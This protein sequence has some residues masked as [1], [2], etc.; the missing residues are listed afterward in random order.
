MYIG[1]DYYPEH[2]P[3]N[4]IEEDIQGIKELGSNMVRIGEFAWH[5]M[6]PKEGEYDFSFFDSVIKKLKKQNID[7]MFGTP[8][9]TFP[10]WLAKQHPSILSKDENGAVKLS[11]SPRLIL[12]WDMI[13][14]EACYIKTSGL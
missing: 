3:E 1:V 5:L 14:I 8:T 4:M 11:R 2:W 10:A 9:A 13:L 12:H 7:V 6:E